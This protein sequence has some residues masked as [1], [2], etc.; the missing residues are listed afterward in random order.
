MSGASTQ[1]FV[2]L[3]IIVTLTISV[4]S[5]YLYSQA[6]RL[7][8]DSN[9]RLIEVKQDIER[10]T[11]LVNEAT[12][13]FDAANKLVSEADRK[14][15]EADSILKETEELLEEIRNQGIANITSI[16]VGQT[17]QIYYYSGE[18]LL[19][20]GLNLS[21]SSPSKYPAYYES[22]IVDTTKSVV[23]VSGQSQNFEEFARITNAQ[24][25]PEEPIWIQRPNT[26]GTDTNPVTFWIGLREF[27]FQRRG[28]LLTASREN[29][30]IWVDLKIQVVQAHTNLVIDQATVHL[31]FELISGGKALVTL[32]KV[33]SR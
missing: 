1:R 2:T 25:E 28:I 3:A 22:N 21:I 9:L 24:T 11:A 10:M 27:A 33:D 20:V 15:V 16:T 23:N 17:P 8:Q 12:S 19:T 13:K 26:L 6:Y 32:T 18:A 7:S 5:G 14:L 31:K 29:V 30:T 4:W